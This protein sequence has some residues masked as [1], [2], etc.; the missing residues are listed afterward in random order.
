MSPSLLGDRGARVRARALRRS[1]PGALRDYLATAVPARD[2]PLGELGLLAVDIETT[3][4]DPR[5]DAVLSVGLVAVDG[6]EVRLGS[7]RRLVVAGAAGAGGVGQSAVFHGLTDD[8]LAA[9]MP[10]EEV[11]G[12]VL[13]ALRGR[14]LLAHHVRIETGFLGA[15]CARLWGAAMPCVTVD[16]MELE[17]RAVSRGWGSEPEAG[18]LRLGSA[19][20]R[21]GLPSYRS[22]E[23]LTDALACAELYLAQRAELESASPGTTLTLRHVVA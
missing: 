17:R 9:G 10:L 11:V 7:A 3:G 19:R 15:A 20:E 13:D 12:V 8:D 5:S 6:D 21:R 2:V 23:C 1:A 22:H 14:V 18:S 16:T 4:L